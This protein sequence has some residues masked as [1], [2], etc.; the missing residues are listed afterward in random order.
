MNDSN[1]GMQ[2]LNFY[3]RK[4]K[5]FDVNIAYL[6]DI[7]KIQMK[8]LYAS[9]KNL[10]E[11]EIKFLSERYRFTELKKITAQEAASL[12]AVSLYKY[13]EKENAI[14]IKLIPYFLENEKKLKEELNEA[15]RIEAKRR[16]KN[17]FK[18]NFR[19]GDC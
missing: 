17:R 4:W 9:L 7:E 6:S 8:I 5:Y 19:S 12:R 15:V 14:G 18:S 16:R 13:K 3:L 1:R 10:N 2:L 11:D